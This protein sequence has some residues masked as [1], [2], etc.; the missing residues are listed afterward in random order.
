MEQYD[1]PL[2]SA[3][4]HGRNDDVKALLAE[5]T[6]VDDPALYTRATPLLLASQEGQTDV[7]TT[8]ITANASLTASTEYI[9]IAPLWAATNNGLVDAVKILIAANAD[10]NQAKIDNGK[11]A[12]TPLEDED[13]E[14]D[15]DDD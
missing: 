8:L 6:D 13:D 10:V 7:M 9:N 11:G 4:R 15:W 12:F 1:T 14:G 5:G 2:C 3:A